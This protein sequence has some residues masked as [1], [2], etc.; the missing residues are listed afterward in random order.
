MFQELL[1]FLNQGST[2]VVS[3]VIAM[4]SFLW[5]RRQ[6][7]SQATI[8]E[9]LEWLRRQQ[10]SELVEGQQELLQRISAENEEAEM[11][12]DFLSD[13]LAQVAAVKSPLDEILEKVSGN[14]AKLDL[15]LEEL[16]AAN[17]PLSEGQLAVS[18]QVLEALVAGVEG[19]GYRATL[20]YKG[21]NPR[22]G[23]LGLVW[24]VGMKSPHMM[25][26]D[27]VGGITDNRLSLI[28]NPDAS[29]CL[30]SFDG[31]GNEYVISSPSFEKAQCVTPVATWKGRDV[32]LWVNG[33]HI[34][35][36]TMGCGFEYLGPV[37]FQGIDINGSLSADRV[38]IVD[39]PPSLAFEKDGVAHG[40]LLIMVKLWRVAHGSELIREFWQN[41][42]GGLNFLP[43]DEVISD[44]TSQ[45]AGGAKAPDLFQRR[46]TAYLQKGDYELAVSD[47]TTAITMKSDPSLLRARAEALTRLG[48]FSEALADCNQAIILAP[49]DADTHN[50]RAWLLATCPDD[51]IRNGRNALQDARKACELSSDHRACLNTL[52]AAFAEAGDFDNAIATQERVP[53]LFPTS[54]GYGMEPQRKEAEAKLALYKK[55][56]PYRENM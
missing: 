56:Y 43:P 51:R 53:S 5:E 3:L 31:D 21:N 25:L 11:T 37:L 48:R 36:K 52:A 40:S 19:A 47:L 33:Q 4:K 27:Y 50:S 45:I 29:I 55:G 54:E 17:A 15:I 8:G 1:A 39:D 42:Y 6:A 9:Y 24:R 30:R 35:S 46:G 41:P 22:E 10:H 49:R 28:L 20:K 2:G 26:T 12:R 44:S 7:G 13:L 32:S 38:A 18:A 34:G 23:T 14:D 16:S